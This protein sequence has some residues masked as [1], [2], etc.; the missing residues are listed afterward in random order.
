MQ[1][2]EGSFATARVTRPATHAIG[3]LTLWLQSHYRRC[4]I[5]ASTEAQGRVATGLGN[6]IGYQAAGC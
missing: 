3:N 1:S 4:R 2:S 5:S 6:V